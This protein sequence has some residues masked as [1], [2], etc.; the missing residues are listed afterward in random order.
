MT[1][2]TAD[3]LHIGAHQLTQEIAADHALNQPTG[4]LRKPCTNLHQNTE[5]PKVKHI[6]KGIQ[7]SQ[8]MIHKWTFMVLMTIPVIQ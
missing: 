8:Q 6:L 3:H 1:L 5:D 4:Q 7:E 2:H